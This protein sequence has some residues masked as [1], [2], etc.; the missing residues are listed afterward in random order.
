MC[1]H[2]DDQVKTTFKYKGKHVNSAKHVQA[3]VVLVPLL[4]L[5]LVPAVV[6]RVV[7]ACLGRQL[8]GGDS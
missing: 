2:I 7:A 5:L 1:K 4:L 3:S 6:V 8:R